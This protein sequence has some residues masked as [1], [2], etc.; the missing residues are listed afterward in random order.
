MYGKKRRILVALGTSVLG[1][2][3]GSLSQGLVL[4]ILA[5][6]LQG[7][8]L[9][10]IPVGTA[11][12]HDELPR[13]RVPLAVALMS[14]SLAIGAGAGL[15]TDRRAPGVASDVPDH[16]RRRCGAAGPGDRGDRRVP[17]AKRRSHYL[18]ALLLSASLT[19]L[20]LTLSKGGQ[21]VGPSPRQP[22][23]PP[24]L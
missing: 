11:T 6:A 19:A 10:L 7:V 5:R 18:G 24:G 8:G 16:R 3:V 23:S 4:L 12:M 13:E 1:S 21:W 14:A 2:L 9:A 20:L 22:S 15:S 17:G